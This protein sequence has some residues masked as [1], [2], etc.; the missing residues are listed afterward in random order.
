MDSVISGLHQF[1]QNLTRFEANL[2][3]IKDLFPEDFDFPFGENTCAYHRAFNAD[4]KANEVVDGKTCSGWDGCEKLCCVE[5]ACSGESCSKCMAEPGCA[6]HEEGN[7]CLN[8]CMLD[9]TCVSD[10][11]SEYYS[12]G[13]CPINV[14]CEAKIA[15][16][17]ACKEGLN[18][19]EY[20][21][22][23]PETNGCMQDCP[24]CVSVGGAWFEGSCYRD[25]PY[26]Q[27]YNDM[28]GCYEALTQEMCEYHDS[29]DTCNTD[30]RCIWRDADNKCDY[31][32]NND[33]KHIIEK[34]NLQHKKFELSCYPTYPKQ[35]DAGKYE[36]YDWQGYMLGELNYKQPWTVIFDGVNVK[37]K[38]RDKLGRWGSLG[39]HWKFESCA[40]ACLDKDGCNFVLWRH[41]N[42][43]CTSFKQC[44]PETISP[45][46]LC[47]A[48]QMTK[49]MLS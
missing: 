30:D 41:F 40:Q 37:C 34:F 6:W 28:Y 4:C 29:C 43:D 16:C 24:D 18:I 39:K 32:Y 11:N 45:S 15:E 1:P 35:L 17:F 20:C 46:R 44:E 38:N 47:S 9:G 19:F 42:M 23:Y 48:A 21:N 12:D 26:Q 3:N 7:G 25:C 33:K 22:L 14:C 31:N 10:P 5:D 36:F 27:C 13:E 2:R 8:Y 49:N